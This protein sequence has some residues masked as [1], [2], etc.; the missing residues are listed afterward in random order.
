MRKKI[1][2]FAVAAVFLLL[3]LPLPAQAA[4]PLD[5]IKSYVV[6]VDMRQDGTMDI[7]Y[8]LD[9]LVLDDTAEG[10]LTWVKI[11]IP[12]RHADNIKALTPTISKIRYMGDGGSYV[13]IDLDRAYRAGET[14]SFAFSIH[15]SYMYTLGD[16]CAY[17]FTP[18]WFEGIQVDSL[19]V[20][21][22]KANVASSNAMSAEGGYL[23][24]ETMLDAGAR[25]EVTVEY[26][27]GTLDT[28]AHM[29]AEKGDAYESIIT[30]VV[31]IAIAVVG[32]GLFIVKHNGYKG[33]FGRGGTHVPTH[34]HSCA[35]AGCACACACACAGG[36]RAGCSVK[37]FY[38]AGVPM[39]VLRK[40][41]K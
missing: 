18:G 13:R 5:E 35:C 37:H 9:W 14:V 26:P 3:L 40:K 23:T 25:Y 11:G 39:Q 33:G 17:S 31:I 38:G 27:I 1:L 24:W 29:Q 21:W 4:K 6:T 7:Q 36:G 22:N 15:Q 19:K 16:T 28:A 10:P 2:H 32:I 20:L 12:N 30:S 41:L 8:Q 34:R